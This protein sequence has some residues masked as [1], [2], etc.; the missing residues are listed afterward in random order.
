[1]NKKDH[2]TEDSARSEDS[3]SENES[4]KGVEEMVEEM[5]KEVGI[6]SI[7]QDVPGLIESAFDDL[8]SRLAATTIRGLGEITQEDITSMFDEVAGYANSEAEKLKK[9]NL[10]KE[11]KYVFETFQVDAKDVT[12]GDSFTVYVNASDPNLSGLYEDKDVEERVKAEVE[13]AKAKVDEAWAKREEALEKKLPQEAALQSRTIASHGYRIQKI[14]GQEVIGMPLRIRLRGIDAPESG[15]DYGKEAQAE[16]AKI[17]KGKKLKVLIYTHDKYYRWVADIYCDGE[18]VQ[19]PMLQNGAAW[20]YAYYDKRKIL[21][22]WQDEAKKKG[23]GLWAQ[24]KPEEPWDWRMNNK[25]RG[26]E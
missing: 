4:E 2:K 5:L 15:Q 17:V 22:E 1:M 12:D 26:K 18:L 25:K 10:P 3:T 21:E 8:D 11:V 14:H 13:L 20:H 24:P 19:K 7:F 6:Q 16:L 9:A 23:I